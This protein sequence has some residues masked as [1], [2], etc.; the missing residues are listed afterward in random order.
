MDF[1]NPIIA[2]GMFLFFCAVWRMLYVTVFNIIGERKIN[3]TIK[4]VVN[5]CIVVVVC[6]VAYFT[7]TG[8]AKTEDMESSALSVPGLGKPIE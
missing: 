3:K 8:G 1:K 6:I 5:L 4:I 7:L 2:I